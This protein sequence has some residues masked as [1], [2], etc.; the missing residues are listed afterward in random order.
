[1]RSYG[2]LSSDEANLVLHLSEGVLAG[3]STGDFTEDQI[4]D[5]F[6]GMME[7]WGV[8]ADVIEE[9]IEDFVTEDILDERTVVKKVK[10]KLRGAAPEPKL[11]PKPESKPKESGGLMQMLKTALVGAVKRMYEKPEGAKEIAKK[12]KSDIKAAGKEAAKGLVR[13]GMKMVFGKWLKKEKTATPHGSESVAEDKRSDVEKAW[14]KRGTTTMRAIDPD[15]YPPIQGMEG[16][17][18]YR[19]GR[20]L[21]YDPKHG[22]YY[23][24]KTDRYLSRSEDPGR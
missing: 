18:Q 17:F 22:R 9:V 5:V 3:I 13:K 20:I 10:R 7:A 15:E 16:P 6:F 12:A 11:K 23:D 4:E 24:R 1:M 8:D 19:N 2:G 14:A 21:Y